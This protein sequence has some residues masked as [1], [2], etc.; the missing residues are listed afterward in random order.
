MFEQKFV[1]SLVVFFTCGNFTLIL[2]HFNFL[3][4]VFFLNGFPNPLI[5][6]S[7]P[8]FLSE[9]NFYFSLFIF[10]S[11]AAFTR[12]FFFLIFSSGFF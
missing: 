5:A 11:N 1:F 12:Q 4:R 6:H 8:S 7:R 2:T 9:P 10:C 3:D